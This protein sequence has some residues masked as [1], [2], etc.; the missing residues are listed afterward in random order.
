[1]QR[2]ARAL[3]AGHPWQAPAAVRTAH[4]ALEGGTAELVVAEAVLA[5]AA[6]SASELDDRLRCR[7]LLAQ[8]L[9]RLD[10]LDEAL[11]L[12]QTLRSRADGERAERLDRFIASLQS[13]Q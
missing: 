7:F 10:R 5:V 2:A 1:W 11:S 9:A 4:C 13:A 12:A 3:P 8:V 6:Q